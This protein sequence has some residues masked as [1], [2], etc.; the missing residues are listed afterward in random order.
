M[1]SIIGQSME[2]YSGT[3]MTWIPLV[4]S[5]I[6]QSVFISNIQKKKKFSWRLYKTFKRHYL[7]HFEIFH[8]HIR[9]TYD[10]LC[11][12][13]NI[14]TFWQLIIKKYIFFN[15]AQPPTCFEF[16]LYVKKKEAN[17]ILLN[18]GFKFQEHLHYRSKVWYEMTI[19]F[20]TVFSVSFLLAVH[21][22]PLNSLCQFRAKIPSKTKTYELI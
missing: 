13:F 14:I 7:E 10:N 8:F 17:N 19:Y 1:I 11:L 12:R 2:I 16:Y 4:A 21:I 9:I 3:N 5:H 20:C 6:R 15:W 18:V 22:S